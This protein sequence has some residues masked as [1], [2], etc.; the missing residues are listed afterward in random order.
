VVAIDRILE[1]HALDEWEGGFISEAS[2]LRANDFALSEA[3]RSLQL[4]LSV[5]FDGNFYWRSVVEDLGRR[6]DRPLHVFTLTLPVETCIARDRERGLPHGEE[7]A[8]QVYAKSTEFEFG[9]AVDASRPVAEIVAAMR[10]RLPM[11][12]RPQPSGPDR[13]P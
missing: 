12:G 11:A 13:G 8:R 9:V 3:R 4:E 5:V 1:E 6:L 7:A 10:S 2:F